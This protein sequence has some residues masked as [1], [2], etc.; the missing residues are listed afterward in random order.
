MLI[1]DM[2]IYIYSACGGNGLMEYLDQHHPRTSCRTSLIACTYY[3]ILI[4]PYQ[5]KNPN[6]M[7][8]ITTNP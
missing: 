6:S 1:A 3:S 2:L 4:V 5:C 8:D 7:R